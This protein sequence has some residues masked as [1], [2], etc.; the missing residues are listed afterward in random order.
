MENLQDL[1][2]QPRAYKLFNASRQ[3]TQHDAIGSRD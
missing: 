1:I 3:Y 2:L